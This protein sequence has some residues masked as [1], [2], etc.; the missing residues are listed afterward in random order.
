[1]TRPTRRQVQAAWRRDQF[2][3]VALD[4]FAQ[5][6][7]ENTTVKDLAEAAGTAQG[8]I[9]HYFRGK[10]EMLFAVVDRHS[11]L[12]ELRRMLSDPEGRPAQEILLEIALGFHALLGRNEKLVRVFFRESQTNPEVAQ[13]LGTMIAEGVGLLARYL[14]GRIAAGELRP[15][16]AEVTA[17]SLLYTIFMLH[18][19]RVPADRFI[20]NLVDNQL[21]GIQR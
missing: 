12:P 8:L 7:L 11:F 21:R 13:R 20:P 10:E 17:R 4:L 1:M 9:Y 19:T 18:L 16:D 3:D 15:H 14:E 5:K 2:L 6:G